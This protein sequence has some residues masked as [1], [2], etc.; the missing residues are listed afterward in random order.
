MSGIATLC[1]RGKNQLVKELDECA[2]LVA[3]GPDLAANAARIQYEAEALHRNEITGDMSP[4]C[5][6]EEYLDDV[7]C[8]SKKMLQK[9]NE[10]KTEKHREFETVKS[11]NIMSSY[12]GGT[13]ATIEPSSPIKIDSPMDEPGTREGSEVGYN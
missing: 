11:Q 12:R 10:R 4:R 8:K 6:V 3:A 9:L 1:I 7:N 5:Y 13:T 2:K